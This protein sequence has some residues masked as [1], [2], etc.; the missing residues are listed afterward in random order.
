MA[1]GVAPPQPPRAAAQAA[2]ARPSAENAERRKPE[3]AAAAAQAAET[4]GADGLEHD[5][6]DAL[7]LGV[8]ARGCRV[9][10]AAISRAVG[11]AAEYAASRRW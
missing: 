4:R 6:V 1:R 11:A 3:R 5:D 9:C 2:E 10:G 8:S 7:P